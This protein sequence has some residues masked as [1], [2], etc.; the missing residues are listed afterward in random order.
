[1]FVFVIR[2]TIRHDELVKEEHLVF[3]TNIYIANMDVFQSG[4]NQIYR[5]KRIER[6]YRFKVFKSCIL[7][8]IF[9]PFLNT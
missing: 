7:Q 8:I 1:M 6:L 4:L 9:S 3:N 2:V 5:R